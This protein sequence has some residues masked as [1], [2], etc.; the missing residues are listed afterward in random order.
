MLMETWKRI[1]EEISARSL[2]DI[3]RAAAAER[4]AVGRKKDSEPLSAEMVLRSIHGDDNRAPVRD[5]THFPASAVAQLIVTASD[6]QEFGA[7]GSFIRP[8]VVL[9]AG[10]ALFVPGTG[11]ARGAVRKVVVVP[12]R[13]GTGPPPFGAAVATGDYIPDAW[14]LHALPDFDYGLIFVPPTNAV[15]PFQVAALPDNELRGLSVL[16][17]GY[18]VDK[19]IGTQW[20]DKRTIAAVSGGQVAYDID[21]ETGQSGSAVFAFHDG[22]ATAVTVHRFGDPAANY[23]TRITPAVRNDIEAHL[24]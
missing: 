9:T 20:Y 18:P 7:T 1:D 2:P 19:P 10:H 12:G 16:I 5:T 3:A 17:S 15:G 13:N 14:R 11:S 4:K 21:T 6:G 23:G 24:R 22:A 8:N